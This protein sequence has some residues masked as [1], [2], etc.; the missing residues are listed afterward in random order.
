MARPLFIDAARLPEDLDRAIATGTPFR[1]SIVGNKAHNTRGKCERCGARARFAGLGGS[2]CCGCWS[3]RK[4]TYRPIVEGAAVL[5]ACRYGLD[6][7][8]QLVD[9]LA[10]PGGT[11]RVRASS[12]PA[13]RLRYHINPAIL[14]EEMLGGDRP[15]QQLGLQLAG[16]ARVWFGLALRWGVDCHGY[17]RSGYP[18][19]CDIPWGMVTWVEGDLRAYRWLVRTT[20]LCRNA[21]HARYGHDH[22]AAEQ[23]GWLLPRC[24]DLGHFLRVQPGPLP[25]PLNVHLERRDDARS[26]A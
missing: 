16:L 8:E 22:A 13:V 4:K 12:A 5:L 1:V 7:W 23:V 15:Y 2:W 9:S 20:M 6:S 3:I 11:V 17:P 26:A 25:P 24:A 14:L 19:P 10:G 18:A 21:Y